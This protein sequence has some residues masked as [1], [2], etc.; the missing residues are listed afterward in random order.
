M[1][2]F[3]NSSCPIKMTSGISFW[4][5]PWKAHFLQPHNLLQEDQKC[6]KQLRFR[7]DSMSDIPSCRSKR[8]ES[9]KKDEESDMD[10]SVNLTCTEPAS[11]VDHSNL[12]PPPAVSR[13]SDQEVMC[14]CSLY[15]ESNT[16]QSCL[17]NT[18]YHAPDESYHPE[19]ESSCTQ[20]YKSLQKVRLDFHFSN[21]C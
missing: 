6:K 1:I 9:T 20:K 14:L 17:Q 12:G 18:S 11:K 19:S 7:E 21:C 5:I 3:K 13:N 10:T 8:I 15:T 2:C 16:K 4:S